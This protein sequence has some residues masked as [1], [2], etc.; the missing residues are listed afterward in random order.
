MA[1]FQ[2]E[3]PDLDLDLVTLSGEQILVKPKKIVNG[4]TAIEITNHWIKLEKEQK[5]KR[6]TNEEGLAVME[7]IAKELA[8]IYDKEANW[9]LNNFD[10]ATLNEILMYVAETLGGIKKKQTK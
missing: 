8:Y 9:F 2:A 10:V 3:K 6:E 5:K 7:V 4:Q 1:K